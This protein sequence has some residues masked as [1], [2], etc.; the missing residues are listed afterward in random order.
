[1]A[2]GTRGA[3]NNRRR[4]S[5]LSSSECQLIQKIAEHENGLTLSA[6]FEYSFLDRKPR[7]NNF[8]G[9]SRTLRR[10]GD[11]THPPPIDAPVGSADDWHCPLEHQRSHSLDTDSA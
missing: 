6:A 8:V 10:F 4:C 5:I 7:A 3:K 9:I 11:E 2:I 1:M